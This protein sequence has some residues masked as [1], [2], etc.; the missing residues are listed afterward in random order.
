[1]MEQSEMASRSSR[2]SIPAGAAPKPAAGRGVFPPITLG[3]VIQAV[4][5]LAVVLLL[6]WSTRQ[7]DRVFFATNSGGRMIDLLEWLDCTTSL[8]KLAPARLREISARM[9]WGTSFLAQ[10]LTFVACIAF[11]FSVPW[12]ILQTRSK[13]IAVW[14]TGLSVGISLATAIRAFLI[15]GESGEPFPHSSAVRAGFLSR[16]I[17][18]AHVP[19]LGWYIDVGNG[20]MIVLCCSG[21]LA[22]GA[23]ILHCGRPTLSDR[24]AI[25]ASIA[26]LRRLLTVGAV[27]LI[28]G[29]LQVNF[30][31][32]WAASLLVDADSQKLSEAG[33]SAAAAIILSTGA[34]LTMVLAAT[35]V[36]A[37]FILYRRASNFN[38]N[39][40]QKGANAPEEIP[41]D[42]KEMLGDALKIIGPALTAG[43]LAAL[44]GK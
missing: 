23:T 2:N 17:A 19:Q 26:T 31:Y 29:V 18:Q 33:N 42:W 21:I 44:I 30:E 5:P 11:F 36:P 15:A 22:V 32:R 39:A 10:T 43:P 27:A 16:A 41:L 14:L 6:G 12:Q 7:L 37:G 1:M 28:V 34:L 35:F 38:R 24:E 4:V 8:P 13:Q 3:V 20:L 9:V 40:R 25:R